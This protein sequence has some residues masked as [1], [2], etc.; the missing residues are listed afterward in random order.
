MRQHRPL[1]AI[2]SLAAALFLSAIAAGS[3]AQI[4]FHPHDPGALQPAENVLMDSALG[5][6]VFGHTNTT[7]KAVTFTS[8]ENI[9]SPAQGQARVEAADEVGYKTLCIEIV[10]GFGFNQIEFNVN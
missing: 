9:L 5:F 7:N 2:Q 8:D 6:N 1:R 3:Q 10:P 4:T